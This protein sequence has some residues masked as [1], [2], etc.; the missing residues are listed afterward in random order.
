MK[1]RILSGLVLMV[2]VCSV[3]GTSFATEPPKL[4]KCTIRTF[5]PTETRNLLK[6]FDEFMPD[7]GPLKLTPLFDKLGADASQNF[8]A[9]MFQAGETL[10]E[11]KKNY[12]RD[13][14]TDFA[15]T[16]DKE[17][18]VYLVGAYGSM[19]FVLG[20]VRL[21][22][23]KPFRIM[24][25][26]WQEAFK[27]PW[28]WDYVD[29]VDKVKTFYCGAIVISDPLLNA[30]KELGMA[31]P[32]LSDMEKFNNYY[33]ENPNYTTIP[34]NILRSKRNTTFTLSL[35]LY[36]NENNVTVVSPTNHYHYPPVE[37]PP[38]TPPQTGDS[39]LPLLWGVAACTSFISML[40]LRRRKAA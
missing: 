3:I 24:E 40:L 29:I 22:A 13:H 36:D 9:M 23:N 4:P 19:G 12:Y 20:P 32:D 21:E 31:L 27:K 5:K 39:A 18:Y 28:N 37:V 35:N 7:A 33:S 1:K 30:A 38:T 34:T 6:D 14:I 15:L 2:L 25:Y 17:T 8:F 16:A 10:D 11:A 26:L